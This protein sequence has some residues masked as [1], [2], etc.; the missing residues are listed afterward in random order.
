MVTNMK[1]VA[2]KEIIT[3]MI[4]IMRPGLRER[5]GLQTDTHKPPTPT[6]GSGRLVGF[7]IPQQKHRWGDILETKVAQNEL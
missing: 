2:N 7:G 5:P 6:D 3:A 4:K 1:T